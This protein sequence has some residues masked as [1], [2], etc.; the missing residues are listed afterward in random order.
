M[1]R[2]RRAGATSVN[3]LLRRM[4]ADLGYRVGLSVG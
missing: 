3:C 2:N 4:G 1:A